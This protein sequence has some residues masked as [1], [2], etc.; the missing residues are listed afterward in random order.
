MGLSFRR[1]GSRSNFVDHPCQPAQPD[2]TALPRSMSSPASRPAASA[3]KPRQPESFEEIPRRRGGTAKTGGSRTLGAGAKPRPSLLRTSASQ[4]QFNTSVAIQEQAAFI[5][6]H[7][8]LP[9]LDGRA[10]VQ[11]GRSAFSIP[12]PSDYFFS[13]S[14]L[15]SP[16]L[17]AASTILEEPPDAHGRKTVEGTHK[18][19]GESIMLAPPQPA[20]LASRSNSGPGSPGSLASRNW[21]STSFESLPTPALTP[22]L[23]SDESSSHMVHGALH[24]AQATAQ[25]SNRAHERSGRHGMGTLK[26]FGSRLFKH[27][28]RSPSPSGAPAERSSSQQSSSTDETSSSSGH[29]PP[30]LSLLGAPFSFEMGDAKRLEQRKDS[31]SALSMNI[32]LVQEPPTNIVGPYSNRSNTAAIDCLTKVQDAVSSDLLLRFAGSA[33]TAHL[34]DAELPNHED[35]VGLCGP[36]RR[37]SVQRLGLSPSSAGLELRCRDRERGAAASAI[38]FYNSLLL[39]LSPAEQQ[40]RLRPLKL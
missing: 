14:P 34:P 27:G 28:L 8:S 23:S 24:P 26:R 17:S 25:L 21:S 11:R 10:S 3:A 19:N 13:S 38:R 30:T 36:T 40:H 22:G 1:E 15:G 16:L 35:S 32:D 6:V 20:F 31:I 2:G 18:V 4:L 33:L 9:E 29:G 37:R 12:R 7:A 5:G 39:S